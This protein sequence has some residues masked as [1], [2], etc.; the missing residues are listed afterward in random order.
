MG[1]TKRFGVT[2]S[3]KADEFRAGPFEPSEEADSDDASALLVVA[4][5]MRRA[6]VP[7][8][9]AVVITAA[10]M[11]LFFMDDLFCDQCTTA[12]LAHS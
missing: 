9:D 12:P 11:E 4:R 5:L 3:G 7:R 1:T 6:S 10:R 2:I 8:M